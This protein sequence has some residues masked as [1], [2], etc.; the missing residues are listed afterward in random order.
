MDSLQTTGSTYLD[1]NNQDIKSFALEALKLLPSGWTCRVTIDLQYY[2]S[3]KHEMGFILYAIPP[4][5]RTEIPNAIV[6]TTKEEC[7]GK[8]KKALEIHEML[9]TI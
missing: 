3:G 1:N 8:V 6:G 5:P 4:Q 2:S 7:L 9:K